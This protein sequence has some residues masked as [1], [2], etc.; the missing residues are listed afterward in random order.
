[1]EGDSV[2][3]T[4]ERST[5]HADMYSPSDWMLGVRNAKVNPPKYVVKEL[6]HTDVLH[7]KSLT[8]DCICNRVFAEG[9]ARLKWNNIHS[10]QYHRKEDPTKIFF[11]YEISQPEYTSV[12]IQE[13][14]SVGKLRNMKNYILNHCIQPYPNIRYQVQRSN[15][16]MQEK[17]SSEFLLTASL[18]GECVQRSGRTR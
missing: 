9:G 13:R 17:H 12:D 2:Q 16:S 8:D 15:E 6:A 7:F 14:S 5:K 18:Q 10:F 3:A 1:M 11:K 4:I